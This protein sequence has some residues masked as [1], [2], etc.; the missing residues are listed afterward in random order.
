M[1]RFDWRRRCNF[2]V[3]SGFVVA[4]SLFVHHELGT[5]S[6]TIV[7]IFPLDIL[8]I[9]TA[10][11]S[12]IFEHCWSAGLFFIV[13]R[14]G[15]HGW[16]GWT[17]AGRRIR[18]F[19]GAGLSL[20]ISCFLVAPAI[21]WTLDGLN[22][23]GP[24]GLFAAYGLMLLLLQPLLWWAWGYWT[25]GLLLVRLLLRRGQRARRHDSVH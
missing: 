21:T 17:V 6:S 22:R 13:L 11:V 12:G 20:V 24:V 3:A 7:S 18:G 10:E 25:R 14:S 5:S 8:N 19:V 15:E 2:F 16:R 4:V 9:A 23:L 1:V